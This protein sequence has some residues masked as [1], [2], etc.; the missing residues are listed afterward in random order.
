MRCARCGLHGSRTRQTGYSIRSF[1]AHLNDSDDK[2]VLATANAVL[3]KTAPSGKTMVWSHSAGPG[4]QW[5]TGKN[6]MKN[7]SKERAD[8]SVYGFAFSH[9]SHPMFERGA[10]GRICRARICDGLSAGRYFG[11][12]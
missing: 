4:F 3:E 7:G 5:E 8:Y 11:C 1:L 2:A 6:G 12:R 10:R 9:H